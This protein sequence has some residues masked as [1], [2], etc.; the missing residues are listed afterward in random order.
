MS[1]GSFH[2]ELSL[3]LFK[4]YPS[5]F[6]F[7]Q[8]NSLQTLWV[9]YEIYCDSLHWTKHTSIYFFQTSLFLKLRLGVRVLYNYG[10]KIIRRPLVNLRGITSTPLTFF[11]VLPSH[12]KDHLSLGSV[13]YFERLCSLERLAIRNSFIFEH[14][15]SCSLYILSKF[16]LKTDVPYITFSLFILYYIFLKEIS[17]YVQYIAWKSP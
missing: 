8:F 4:K 9:S 6:C 11:E 14:K 3:S 17:W 12:L 10:L 7:C 2:F 13:L 16:C 1:K 5:W 15:M